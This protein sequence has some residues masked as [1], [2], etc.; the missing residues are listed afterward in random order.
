MSVTISDNPDDS[1][2]AVCLKPEHPLETLDDL[3]STDDDVIYIEIPAEMLKELQ[4][5]A[6]QAV[7]SGF[8]LTL[9]YTGDIVLRHGFSFSSEDGRG[10]RRFTGPLDLPEAT[11]RQMKEAKVLDFEKFT[12]LALL[13]GSGP[14]PAQADSRSARGIPGI[15]VPDTGFEE[16][17]KNE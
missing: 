10:K 6:G 3:H 15:G 17:G 5:Y 4:R 2:N 12:G 8:G 9:L 1:L 16:K 13:S 7:K 14:E 11:E